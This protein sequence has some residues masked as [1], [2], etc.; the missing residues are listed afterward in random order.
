[1][2]T[3]KNYRRQKSSY[4]IA[5]LRKRS[6]SVN[7]SQKPSTSDDISEIFKNFEEIIYPLMLKDSDYFR[8][9]PGIFKIMLKNEDNFIDFSKILRI[10]DAKNM[11]NF[12][13]KNL[14]SLEK[15]MKK[16]SNYIN[17][18]KRILKYT[19]LK[20]YKGGLYSRMDQL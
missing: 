11:K 17:K 3:T 9:S 20:P 13:N 15:R 2:I 18:Q 10:L 19:S 14:P 4:I 7:Y 6:D 5:K 16:F 8:A 12:D 1:M